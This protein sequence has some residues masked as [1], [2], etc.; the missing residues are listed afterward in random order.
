MG[1]S[2]AELPELL[3]A[4][5]VRRMPA[6]RREWGAAMLAELAMLRRPVTRWRFALDCTRVA[7]FPPITFWALVSVFWVWLVNDQ[8]P[9]FLGTPNCD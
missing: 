9:C 1:I 6:E 7:L 8:M 4:S 2:W 5:A 3:L